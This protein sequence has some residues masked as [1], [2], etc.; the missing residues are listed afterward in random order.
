MAFQGTDKVA[1][2]TGAGGAIGRAIARKLAAEGIRVVV[3]DRARDTVEE[4]AKLIVESGGEAL[5]IVADVGSAEQ[6]ERMVADTIT[7][8]GK[9][10]IMVSNAGVGE[11]NTFLDLPVQEWERT[12]RIN[13]T[14]PFLCGQAAARDM[15]TRNWGRIINTA[16]ISGQRAGWAR[17]A[18]GTSK[19]G[20]IQLTK[21]MAMELARHGITANAIGPGPIET[22]MTRSALTPQMREAYHRSVPAGR[23]GELDEVA[24]AVSFLVSEDAGYINGHCLNIDGGFVA[25]GL[26]FDD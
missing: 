11:L 23:F 20:L 12:L 1:I 18:Y 19:A 25:A 9:V 26:N 3:A 14:G 17:T 22:E 2:V 5:P 6:V 13:L 10:D 21:Q 8:F 4:S 15:V 24:A 16:S 7:A